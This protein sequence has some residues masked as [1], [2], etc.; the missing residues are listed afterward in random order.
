MFFLYVVKVMATDAKT[1]H[2]VFTHQ[3]YLGIEPFLS[4]GSINDLKK[5]FT[6]IGL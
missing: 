3:T 1:L 4:D 6:N 5:I 2:N